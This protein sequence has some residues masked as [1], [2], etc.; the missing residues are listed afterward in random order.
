MYNPKGF[1]KVAVLAGGPSSERAISIRSGRAVYKALKKAGCDVV[2]EDLTGVGVKRV[3]NKLSADLVFLA[4]HGRFGEDGTIQKVLENMGFPYTG[5]GVTASKLALDKIASKK[6]FE[7]RGIPVP[8]YRILD[9]RNAKKAKGFLYPLVVKPQNEGSSIGLSIVKRNEELNDAFKRAFRYSDKI[10]VE[11]FIEGREITVG[12]LDEKPLPVIEIVPG[13]DFYDFYAKY[14]DKK[15]EYMVPASLPRHIYK[16]AQKLG[17]LAHKALRCRDF[18]R[19]DMILSERGDIF[20]LEV[21]TIPG[22]TTRSLLPKAAGSAG[23]R[24][25]ELCMKLLELALKNRGDKD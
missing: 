9:R 5:S 12:I 17:L 16:R 8:P 13:R 1:G 15:T 20:V 10:I 22:L 3:M 7:K 4:L 21:N 25:D 2:W 14:K 19:V 6:I 23:I 24:F 11:R 18:S